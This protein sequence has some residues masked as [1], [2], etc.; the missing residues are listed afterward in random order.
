MNVYETKFADG[1]IELIEAECEHD[2]WIE[3][4]SAENDIISTVF[5]GS[6]VNGIYV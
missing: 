6:K 4:D 2:V 5:I 1:T 3:F